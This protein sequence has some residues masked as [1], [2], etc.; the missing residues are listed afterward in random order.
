MIITLSIL[1]RK[2]NPLN[3]KKG[4]CQNPTKYQYKQENVKSLLFNIKSKKWM[5]TDV[6]FIQCFT[7]SQSQQKARKRKE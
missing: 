2:G 5:P 4:I 6:A 1:G 7:V 3:L